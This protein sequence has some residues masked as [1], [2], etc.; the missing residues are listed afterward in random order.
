M[1][2]IGVKEFFTGPSKILALHEAPSLRQE[3]SLGI[4]VHDF[5]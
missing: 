1:S 4:F 5:A 3:A 2:K